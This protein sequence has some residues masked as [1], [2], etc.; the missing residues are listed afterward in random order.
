MFPTNV[1]L[2]SVD[3]A[4]Q[5]EGAGFSS[6]LSTNAI[7]LAAPGDVVDLGDVWLLPLDTNA[8]CVADLWEQRHG[9]TDAAGDADGDGDVD[10]DDLSRLLA[11]WGSTTAGCPVRLVICSMLPPNEG[12]TNTSTCAITAAICWINWLRARFA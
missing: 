10:D 4:F 7:V 9:T 2:P 11:N 6:T 1:W 3:W 5:A 8:N 12:E